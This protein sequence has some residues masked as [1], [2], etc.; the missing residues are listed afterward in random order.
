MKS[1][2]VAAHVHSDWSYDGRWSL[3]QIATEFGRRGYDAVLIAEHDRGFDASRRDAHRVACLEASTSTCLLVSG[4]EYSDH[5]NTVHVPVWGD[6]P[7][8]GEGIDTGELLQRV[9]ELDAVAVLAHPARRDC[10]K[11]F[12]PAWMPY[13]RGIE[14]WNRK[15]DGYAPNRGAAHLLAQRPD[16]LPIVSLDFHTPRQFHPL[17]MMIDMGGDLTEAGLCD[18]LRRG[19]VQ[20]TAFGLPALHFVHRAAWPAMYGLER[21]RRGV[22]VRVRQG[23]QLR[24]MRRTGHG[25]S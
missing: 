24:R 11:C 1:I 9:H 4:I 12:D 22:A 7:F 15:Y 14:L 8:L 23:R 13:L 21:A 19:R 2:R 10:W 3:S 6:I 18:A 5:T 17:A 25:T 20:A 16:L